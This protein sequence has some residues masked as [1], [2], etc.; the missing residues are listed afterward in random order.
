MIKTTLGSIG[1][2]IVVCLVS[3]YLTVY[4]IQKMGWDSVQGQITN[5]YVHT[6][7]SGTK[8]TYSPFVDYTYVVDGTT[9]Q[10]NKISESSYPLYRNRNEALDDL[11][12][13]KIGDTVTV[14]YDPD[15]PSYSGLE[16]GKSIFS[17]TLLIAWGLTGL[18]FLGIFAPLYQRRGLIP[19]ILSGFKPQL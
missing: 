12:P 2:F 14:H 11:R 13:Y 3:M 4:Q 15:D 1:T 17:K 6:G 18:L 10:N 8:V 5:V 7:T 9:Y 16:V 19:W